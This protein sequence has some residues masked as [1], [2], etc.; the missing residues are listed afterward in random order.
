MRYLIALIAIAAT[1]YAT[2]LRGVVV[3][4]Y[5]GD[6]ITV[7]LETGDVEKVRLI[8]MD[9]PELR[10]NRHGEAD[11]VYGPAA[12]L[13][14]TALVGG[15]TVDLVLGVK[16]RDGYGRLLAYVYLDGVF[17]NLEMVKAGY[18]KVYTYP[19][20]VAHAAEFL[21]AERQARAEGRGLWR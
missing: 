1:S 19:P 11:L 13:Y 5:D 18:A 20:D 6:T 21:A 16:E 12:G 15:K 4:V 9:A 3:D 14:L 7:R 8:G 17:I 10:T 2:T